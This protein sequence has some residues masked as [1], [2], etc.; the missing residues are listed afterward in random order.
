MCHPA[1]RRHLTL[2]L[3]LVV[4]TFNFVDRQILGILAGPIKQE[5]ALSDT[6]LGLLG[7]LAFAMLY[8]TL[9]VPLAWLAD[10]TGRTWVITASLMVWSGFTALCGVAGGF[11]Q[12]FLCRLGVG[13]GE[14]GGVAPSYAVI[15]DIYP[16][17]QRARAL[18]VYSLGIPL[19]SALGVLFGGYVAAAVNWRAAFVAVGLAGL[20]FAPVFRLAVR[21]PTREREVAELAPRFA[22]VLRLLA[23]KRSF[24]LLAFGAASCSMIGYGLGFW[25][26][27][28]MQRSFG[29][30]LPATARFF[31]GLLLVGG[32]AGVLA[33]G[34][35]GDR[36]GTRDRAAFALVPACAFVVATPLFAAGVLSGSVT[37][38]FALFLLPQALSF[39]WLAPVLTAVQHLVPAPMRAT[40]SA[41]F[42][43]VNNLIGLGLGTLTIGALSD[44]LAGPFGAE[45]LRYAI[46]IALSLYLVAAGLMA[47][48]GR[49]LRR[50]WVG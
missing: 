6:Q 27:S 30:S 28:L 11:W 43:L 13:V 38:A 1:G 39:M 3:L 16:P 9:A 46:L 22:D 41:C 7:G 14:A 23:G 29:L 18:A 4:Y 48:A 8:S 5:L 40:A 15:G 36:L 26:P 19:G 49:H 42:L 25:L 17:A 21:E 34:W 35:L 24:W 45:A 37:A 10:R 50:E 2:A 20:L 47:L 33:G 12:I 31:G 44:A 32:V